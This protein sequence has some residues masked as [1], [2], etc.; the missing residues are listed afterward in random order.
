MNFGVKIL[1]TGMFVG[2]KAIIKK[3]RESVSIITEPNALI[4][5]LN[6]SLLDFE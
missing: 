2:F 6:C 1:M 4:I 3:Q 5:E